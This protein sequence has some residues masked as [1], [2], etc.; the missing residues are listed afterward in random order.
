MTCIGFGL[1]FVMLEC[2]SAQVPATAGAKFCDIY[3]P[4]TWSKADTR[5]TKEQVDSNNR[6]WKKLCNTGSARK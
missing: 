5:L 3:K 6:V 4:I 1:I 2:T